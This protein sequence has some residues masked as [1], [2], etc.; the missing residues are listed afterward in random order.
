VSTGLP[1]AGP[2]PAGRLRETNGLAIATLV[3]GIIAAVPVAIVLGVIALVQI[4]NRGDRGRGL[5]IAGM[6]IAGAWVVVGAIVVTLFVTN[7]VGR[8]AEGRIDKAGY[9]N[10]V[11]LQMGDCLEDFTPSEDAIVLDAVP[12]DEPHRAEVF[13][14][15]TLKPVD[16]DDGYPGG[17][18]VRRRATAGCRNRL[19]T[20]VPREYD[21]Q[22]AN[23]TYFSP[24]RV[25]WGIGDHDVTCFA[26]FDAERS[27]PIESLYSALD[28]LTR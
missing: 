20:Y 5:V 10:E 15:F 7:I 12:C 2:A 18:S 27:A 24:D 6:A 28:G 11:D 3:M 26:N 25:D 17:D 23:M 1:P 13:A 22:L 14:R 16:G 19:R 21:S 9:I 8:D 4:R